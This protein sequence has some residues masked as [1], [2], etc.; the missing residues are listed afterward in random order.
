MWSFVGKRQEK[1][2][3]WLALDRDT[4][5]VVGLAVGKRDEH[6][7]HMLWK[8]LPAVYRQCAMCYT[9]LGEAYKLVLPT[10]RHRASGKNTGFTNHIERFNNTLRQRVARLARNT[11]SFSKKLQNHI[12]AIIFFINYYNKSLRV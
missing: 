4:R 1:V 12:G 2:W 10:Q 8:S 5:E 6:T 9:D 3:V 11:L 7:A